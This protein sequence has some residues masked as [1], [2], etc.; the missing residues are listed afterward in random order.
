MTDLLRTSKSLSIKEKN[1]IKDVGKEYAKKKYDQR[2][3]NSTIANKVGTFPKFDKEQLTLGKVL[4]KGGFGTVYEVR[5]VRVVNDGSSTQKECQFIADHCLRDKDDSNSGGARYAIKTLSTEIVQDPGTFILAIMDMAIETRILC[6]C[7][8]PNIIKARAFAKISPFNEN[9]FIMM[10]RLYDTM[11]KRIKRWATSTKRCQ[12]LGGKIFDRKGEKIKEI[13]EKKLVAAFD[14]SDA[15]GYLHDRNIVYRDIKPE[16]IG[17]DVRDDVKLFDFGLATEL[18]DERKAGGYLYNLTGM[19][20][21]PRYMSPEVANEQ[22]YNE[23]CDIYSFGILFW[24]ML[25]MQTSFEIYGM[26]AFKTRVWNGEHKRPFINRAWPDSIKE[27]LTCSWHK[28]IEKR[29]SFQ[30]ITHQLR[31]EC[32]KARDGD[33]EGL[34]HNQRRSTFVF[35]TEKRSEL[36]HMISV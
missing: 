29:P 10:D 7:D 9:Y 1:R 6:D 20:G 22:K 5:G 21:S 26:Q 25:S 34:E 36:M 27:L 30:F 32:V 4:G 3:L 11:G 13:W 8:H 2:F 24:E 12:G 31:K 18:K 35:D 19:T 17:F 23:K 14:L 33:E 15:L 16:N 28:D